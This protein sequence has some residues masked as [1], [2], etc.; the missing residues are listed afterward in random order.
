MAYQ[1][2][3]TSAAKLLD[4]GRSGFGTV[5]RAKAISPLLVS[6]IERV[7][8]FANL[9]GNDRS[10]VIFVHRRI[11]AANNRVHLLSRICDA[12]A[13]YTGR[14]NHIAHHLIVSQEEVARAA[15]RG[16]TPADVLRQ[17]PWLGSWEGSARFFSAEEDVALELFQPLGRQSAR[18]QWAGLTGNPAHSRILAWEGA[19]RTGVLLVTRE[20]DSLALMAEA[21]HEFGPQSWS[22]SFTT[23]LETTDE[24]SDLDWIVAN[25]ENFNEIQGRCGSRALL[26]LGQPQSLPL[27]P[28]PIQKI[29]EPQPVAISAREQNPVVPRT[30]ITPVVRVH[31]RDAS[32]GSIPKRVAAPV[33]GKQQLKLVLGI[34]AL[35]MTLAVLGLAVWK[36]VT[37]KGSDKETESVLKLRE[38]REQAVKR[39]QGADFSKKDWEDIERAAGAENF[40]ALSRFAVEFVNYIKEESSSTK[41]ERKPIAP[42]SKIKFPASP[43][44]IGHMK[45][46]SNEVHD[47]ISSPSDKPL[48]KIVLIHQSLQKVANQLSNN[49]FRNFFDQFV[50]NLISKEIGDLLTANP[51]SSLTADAIDQLNKIAILLEQNSEN[52]AKAITKIIEYGKDLSKS[53]DQADEEIL[54]LSVVP[55]NYVKNLK[56]RKAPPP[57]DEPQPLVPAETPEKSA[58]DLTKVPLFQMVVVTRDELKEGVELELLKAII[59]PGL[60]EKREEL[61][62]SG[63]SIS[64][65]PDNK[66]SSKDLI[67]GDKKDY[68]SWTKS[69][70]PA[71]LKYS[72]GGKFS[73]QDQEIL[74]VKFS[75]GKYESYIVV[76]EESSDPIVSGVNFN[77]Q[78]VGDPVIIT[79]KITELIKSITFPNSSSRNLKFDID[80]PSSSFLISESNGNLK[81]TRPAKSEPLIMFYEEDAKM[82][83]A[84]LNE[85]ILKTESR[86]NTRSEKTNSELNKSTA[87]GKIKETMIFAIGGGCLSKKLNLDSGESIEKGHMSR[88]R[89][90]FKNDYKEFEEKAAFPESDWGKYI[91]DIKK[92]IGGVEIDNLMPLIGNKQKWDTLTKEGTASKS[93][94]DAITAILR[95]TKKPENLPDIHEEIKNIKGITVQTHEGRV[96]FIATPN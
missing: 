47:Y 69:T 75:K 90:I 14:T 84:A 7:S 13:D 67:L 57:A 36:T 89:E 19:P 16:L 8:Q 18:A 81:V 66:N 1:L 48:E 40:E 53:W 15:D 96:L 91:E 49:E 64:A 88:V 24:L 56:D 78:V 93:I 95:D 76:D 20:A 9:R 94:Q 61:D 70:V 23:S 82:V 86:G 3:Y 85:F 74:Q 34:V 38:A 6:A 71:S 25:P 29:P 42:D 12:G 32:S 80:P 21:L 73:I 55:S 39:M 37:P 79:G 11:I 41:L 22:R 58:P 35:A 44:W 17:F 54:K 43:L 72:M 87:L 4:A 31:V 33:S 46:A 77:L 59:D 60:K 27:P 62:L 10:R 63:L 92:K 51:N 28:E 52:N 83:E 50:N 30:A 26:D 2:V 45:T 65:I 5:A 68:Y